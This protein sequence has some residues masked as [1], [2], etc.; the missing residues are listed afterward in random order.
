M[1]KL[2]HPNIVKLYEHFEDNNY[3]YFL[4]EYIPK[5]IYTLNA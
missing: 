4:M 1:Y 3:C 5:G 2:H